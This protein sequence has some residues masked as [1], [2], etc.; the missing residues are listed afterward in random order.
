M[1]TTNDV[2]VRRDRTEKG[3]CIIVRRGVRRSVQG[4]KAGYR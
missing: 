3:G 1:K 4:M 2:V